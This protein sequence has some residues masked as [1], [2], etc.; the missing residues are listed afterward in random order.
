[1]ADADSIGA[2]RAAIDAAARRVLAKLHA[3][4]FRLRRQYASVPHIAIEIDAS[5]LTAL[6]A[7]EDVASVTLDEIHR[8]TLAES[9]PLVQADQTWAAGYDGDGTVV[10][11]IDTGVD[12][13][14]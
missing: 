2:Q 10:A 3:A 13:G 12:A 5:A 14:S 9:A 7:A 8:P 1:M 6:E 11:V 4:S